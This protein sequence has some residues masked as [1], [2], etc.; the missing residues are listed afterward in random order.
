[1]VYTGRGRGFCRTKA[2]LSR[3]NP[4]QVVFCRWFALGS[5]LR[6]QV[7]LS[8]MSSFVAE[9]GTWQA[10]ATIPGHLR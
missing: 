4:W 1:M 10:T 9:Q 6:T 7:L 3:W 8:P 2:K 5:I